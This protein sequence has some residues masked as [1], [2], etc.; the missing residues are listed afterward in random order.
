MMVNVMS[1]LDWAGECTKVGQTL[2]WVW[3]VCVWDESNIGVGG[4]STAGCPP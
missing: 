1:Q 2:F 3:G 4:L